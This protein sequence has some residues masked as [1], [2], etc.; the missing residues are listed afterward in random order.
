MGLRCLQLSWK[1]FSMVEERSKF[2]LRKLLGA[3]MKM[4]TITSLK[5]MFKC[6]MR[7]KRV[8]MKTMKNMAMKRR[9]PRKL[10]YSKVKS[11]KSIN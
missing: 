1:T 6:K 8:V 7:L 2:L 5:W 10:K 11:F 4:T 9:Y 3:L